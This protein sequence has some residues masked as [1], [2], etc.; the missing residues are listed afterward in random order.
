MEKINNH[1]NLTFVAGLKLLFISLRNRGWVIEGINTEKKGVF[2]VPDQ[3][4]SQFFSWLIN[5]INNELEQEMQTRVV[6]GIITGFANQFREVKI[7]MPNFGSSANPS[8]I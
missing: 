4:S 1:Q 5:A 3:Y 6:T 8:T 2:K 7:P